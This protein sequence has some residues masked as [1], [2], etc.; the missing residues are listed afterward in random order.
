M[1]KA[2]LTWKELVINYVTL[3]WLSVDELIC[4]FFPLRCGVARLTDPTSQIG[5]SELRRLAS[6][7]QLVA[8]KWTENGCRYINR[9]FLVDRLPSSHYRVGREEPE[10]SAASPKLSNPFTSIVRPLHHCWPLYDAI[11]L[12][13]FLMGRHLQVRSNLYIFHCNFKQNA[14]PVPFLSP[15]QTA[16]SDWDLKRTDV[17]LFV[18]VPGYQ[19]INSPSLCSRMV[20]GVGGLSSK[21]TWP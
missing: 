2:K 4:D 13:L 17:V 1:F 6:L 14:P 18:R 16:I 8:G 12:T 19:Q 7:P 20:F 5:L 11:F 10:N 15:C 21:Q 3:L 9:G